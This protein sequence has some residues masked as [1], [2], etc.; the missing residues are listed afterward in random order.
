MSVSAAPFLERLDAEARELLL[1]VAS[2][3]SFERGAIL[4]RH[5]EPA[6]GAWILRQG[7]VEAFVTRPGGESLTVARLA[8]GSVFGEMALVE[9]GT[10]TATVRVLKDVEVWFISN[11]DFRAVC[12]QSNAAARR[13]QHAVTLLLIERLAALN[14]QVLECDAPEDRPCRALPA[15]RGVVPATPSYEIGAFLPRLAF[16]E[17]C[18]PEEAAALVAKGRF[19]EAARGDV[20]FAPEKRAAP[21]T[22]VVMRGAVEIVAMLPGRERR[23]AVLGPGMLAGFVGVLRDRPHTS[24]AFAREDALLLEF[25]AATLRQLYLAESRPAARLR[26]S[27]QRSLLAAMA[28]TNRTLS[29]LMSEAELAQSR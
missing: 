17:R 15:A 2:S 26:D 29:R 9:R 21:S 10:C 7:A 1:S 12:S 22:F 5:G 25:E 6:R 13:L 24:H 19:V 18:T 20:V 14:Q 16:F 8:S 11:E 27:V 3:M 28:R 23:I 4:V